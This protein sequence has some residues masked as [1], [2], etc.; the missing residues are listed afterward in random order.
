[1][2]A[3]KSLEWKIRCGK[4]NIFARSNSI[5][6]MK[7]RR[8]FLMPQPHYMLTTDSHLPPF[9]SLS[10]IH[11]HSDAIFSNIKSSSWM[12]NW[13][14]IYVERWGWLAVGT[15]GLEIGQKCT[16]RSCSLHCA[17]DVVALFVYSDGREA[18]TLCTLPKFFLRRRQEKR[19]EIFLSFIF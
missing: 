3:K 14:G 13:S 18:N 8:S 5:L 16:H 11:V 7:V 9:I 10:N 19:W 2:P 1:M 4:E 12:E 6:R 17:S 15:V